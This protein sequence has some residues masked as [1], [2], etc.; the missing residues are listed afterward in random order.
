MCPNFHCNLTVR[1]T[2]NCCSK[3][4]GI[5]VKLIYSFFTVTSTLNC[6]KQLNVNHTVRLQWKVGH[7][8]K[9]AL[10]TYCPKTSTVP[11]NNNAS[12]L[13]HKKVKFKLEYISRY[14]S[15][16]WSTIFRDNC[17]E[18]LNLVLWSNKTKTN[19]E[20]TNLID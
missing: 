2:F 14:I 18:N 3:Y 6:I 12:F 15:C 10:R 19:V 13:T 20:K 9:Q 16:V 17:N 5:I 4:S 7:I 8:W 1:F 11:L